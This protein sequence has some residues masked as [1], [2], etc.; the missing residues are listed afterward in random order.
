MYWLWAG[1]AFMAAVA[2]IDPGNFATN[3]QAG[4]QYGYHLLWV[5][6]V[7][8][9]IAM[10]FQSMSAKLGLVT[11]LN[12]AELCQRHFPKPLVWCM[13]LISEL[14]AMAT[15]VAELLGGA[16]GIHLLIGLPLMPSM[17][18]IGGLSLAILALGKT[19]MRPVEIIITLL[20]GII[21]L[22]FLVELFIV[23]VDWSQVIR[24]ST[25][26]SLPDAGAIPLAV[27]IIGAT[28]M[29]HAIY[30][31]SGLTQN[32][33]KQQ[34]HVNKLSL[35]RFSNREVMIALGLAGL[36]NVAMV[37][38]AAGAFQQTGQVVSQIEHAYHLLTPLLGQAA[39]GFFLL[40][41]IAS[42][43][44]SSSVGMLAGD[45]IMQGFVSFRIPIW[46]RRAINII[47]PFIIVG[48][49]MNTTQALVLSQ[50]M[51]SLALPIP[52]VALLYLT[53]KPAIMGP[54]TNQ[55]LMHWLGL[56]GALIIFA[57]NA[58]LLVQYTNVF[59]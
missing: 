5:V 50:I 32:R 13:W 7:S 28:V 25:I 22:C 53:S 18:V 8:N 48:I 39:A 26:P 37:L 15:D 57:L 33:V 29:P 40:S 45:M 55:P 27:G 36:I 2:Y 11:G 59:H 47:P 17:L 58:S 21:G 42:G 56:L 44:A 9:L 12:L 1:P 52:I 41:L 3:I 51:L 34:P 38:L 20:A 6:I 23:P 10:V 30:L 19:S 46:L 54:F 14:A 35:I 49:G 24:Y 43:V 16:I 4:S 31:H